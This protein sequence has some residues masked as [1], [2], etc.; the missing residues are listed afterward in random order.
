MLGAAQTRFRPYVDKSHTDS[1]ALVVMFAYAGRIKPFP[2]GIRTHHQTVTT[3]RWRIVQ[4]A[5]I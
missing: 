4:L 1:R 2:P 5:P 3:F